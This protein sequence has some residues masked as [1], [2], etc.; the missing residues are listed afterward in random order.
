MPSYN[1][2]HTVEEAIDSVLNQ[3]S[4]NWELIIID[5]CST[6]NSFNIF[7][8]ITD[9][10]I[11]IYKNEINQGVAFSRNRGLELAQGDYVCFLD[12]DDYWAPTKLT[13]QT[14]AIN[15]YSEKVL[16]VSSYNIISRTGDFLK[17]ILV[18]ERITYKNLLKTNSIPCLTTMITRDIALMHKFQ[19]VGH[20]DYLF[21]L[22]VLSQ[23]CNVITIKEPLAYYRVGNSSLSSNKLKAA[24]F[25]WNIYRKELNLNL[26]T[27]YYYFIFYTFYALK[28]KL[29]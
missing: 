14:R 9:P 22:G 13:V 12:A 2:A 8:K 21:W 26:I 23:E 18:P 1:S 16:V 7:D 11:S 17:C 28:K 19:K 10:R 5:D 24:K 4:S 6:D 3:D 27:S 20:E 29:F 15:K 25:Q